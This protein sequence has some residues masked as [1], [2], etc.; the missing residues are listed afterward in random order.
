LEDMVD[1]ASGEFWQDRPT[2]VT[3]STGLLG[4]WLTTALVDAGAA[5]TGL[6]RDEVPFSQLR[7]SGYIDRIAT[8]RGDV[9]EYEVIERILNEYEIETVFHLAAQTIVTIAN[10]APLSTFESN[11]K[12][13]WTVLEA[14]RRS[15]TVRRLVI[16]SSDKAYGT[17]PALPYTE[18][19]PLQGRHPY[20]VSK[21]CADLIGQAYAVSHNSPL[22]IARCAN[23]YGGGDLNWNRI[24]PGTIRSVLKG[25]PPIV[26]SDGTPL[27]DYLYV[28]DAA[29]AYMTLA[30]QLHR[31]EVQGE[32]FNFGTNHPRSVIEIVGAII[33]LSGQPDLEPVVLD[34]IRNEIQDQYL[35]SAKAKDVLGWKPGYSLEDGL[36]ETIEWYR[37]FLGE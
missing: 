12:G 20:D 6:V 11:V 25:E 27:R 30:E 31:E 9:T 37:S 7:H 15:P 16:A 17:S 1:S 3:G 22:A 24:V 26:R 2:F 18:E 10:R 29:R 34:D 13:T 14:A 5:V 33:E 36:K 23:M 32:P 4:S 28:K 19:T 21:A 8:V 35:D